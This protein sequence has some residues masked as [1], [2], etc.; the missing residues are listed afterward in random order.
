MGYQKCY[1][2]YARKN[3]KIEGKTQEKDT[4]RIPGPEKLSA[5][6]GY[7]VLPL[8]A[9]CYGGVHL[10]AWTAHFPTVVEMWAWRVAGI[11][12]V[13]TTILHFVW[14]ICIEV[15]VA[16]CF[17]FTK[18]MGLMKKTCAKVLSAVGCT[19]E[20]LSIWLMMLYPVARLYFVVESVVSLRAPPVGTW[21]TVDW[22]GYVPHFS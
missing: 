17:D 15:M 9:G 14:M 6:N 3:H 22:T 19:A 21:E 8:I 11:A 12:V 5:I 1:A 18:E 7:W 4:S 16:R 20:F 10:S 2:V 13:L